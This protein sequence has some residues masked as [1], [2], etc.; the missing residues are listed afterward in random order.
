MS[1][2]SIT[3]LNLKIKEIKTKDN[4]IRNQRIY[5]INS[6]IKKPH[7]PI[8]ESIYRDMNS[9]EGAAR[10]ELKSHLSPRMERSSS[11]HKRRC[12]FTPQDLSSMWCH[13]PE[14]GPANQSQS[15]HQQ[16]PL[17]PSLPP[18]CPEHR[19]KHQ[20]TVKE[21]THSFRL[22]QSGR[23]F[24]QPNTMMTQAGKCVIIACRRDSYLQQ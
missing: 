24:H 13:C 14:H 4:K 2:Q 19:A 11:S 12:Y 18:L 17:P 5:K 20:R 10:G 3:T 16:P 7:S 8:R 1:R 21:T 15:F 23:C 22:Q 9:T 6:L